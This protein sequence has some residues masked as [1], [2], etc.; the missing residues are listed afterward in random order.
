[1]IDNNKSP[2]IRSEP[3]LQVANEKKLFKYRQSKNKNSISAQAK[4][5][6]ANQDIHVRLH[7]FI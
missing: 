7:L 5:V 4:H 6:N 2:N 3:K 1:M